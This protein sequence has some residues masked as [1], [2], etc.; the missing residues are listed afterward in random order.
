MKIRFKYLWL[1]PIIGIY[2]G[3]RTEEE[4]PI[5][6]LVAVFSSVIAL[7]AIMFLQYSISFLVVQLNG[8]RSFLVQEKKFIKAILQLSAMIVKADG[9][10]DQ[11]QKK[12]IKTRL[13]EEFKPNNAEKYY[14]QFLNYVDQ[15]LNLVK[16]GKKINLEFDSASKA[17]LVFLL[18]QLAMSDGFLAKSEIDFLQRISR[19]CKIP[20]GTIIQTINLFDF[21]SERTTEQENKKQQQRPTRSRTSAIKKAYAA[22][23]IPDGSDITIVKSAYRKLAKIHHPD[24][25]ALQGGARLKS[26]TTKFQ[27]I[28]DAYNLLKEHLEN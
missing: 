12:L 25:V 13:D 7:V 22:L 11:R 23:G 1:A 24:K 9:E 16:I 3:Y 14:Q 8:K 4:F 6:F 5:Q 21:K 26:A 18:V 2:L 17:Q 20:M 27:I 19:A 28:S 10:V 15:D